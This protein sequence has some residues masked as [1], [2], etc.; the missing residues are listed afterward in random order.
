VQDKGL[1]YGQRPAKWLNQ[2]SK[3]GIALAKVDSF[4]APGGGA[5]ICGGGSLL[6]TRNSPRQV[7][8]PETN[9]FERV[10]KTLSTIE[11]SEL[12]MPKPPF[13][14]ADDERHARRS[15]R[16]TGIEWRRELACPRSRSPPPVGYPMEHKPV[17][18]KVSDG[19]AH[20]NRGFHALYHFATH[21]AGAAEVP[22]ERS[23]YA[24]VA[25][26]PPRGGKVE[27]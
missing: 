4:V 9:S 14:T 25:K 5:I 19:E 10:G 20:V 6:L 12:A 15:V 22:R 7:L 24:P 21:P 17:N 26:G 2:G 27:F 13:G 18:P 16:K 1:V 11:T 23:A 3:Y 8:A